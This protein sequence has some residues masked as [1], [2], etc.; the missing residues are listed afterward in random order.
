MV[1][2]IKAQSYPQFKVKN[3]VLVQNQKFSE[4]FQYK[5]HFHFHNFIKTSTT[6]LD[7]RN[8]NSA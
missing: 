8:L 2:F 7:F 1:I 3:I 4:N 5:F 6:E